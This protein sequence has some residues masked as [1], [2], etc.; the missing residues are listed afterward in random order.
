M[1]DENLKRGR[2]LQAIFQK[3]GLENIHLRYSTDYLDGLPG[4]P[5]NHYG[6][7]FIRG[8]EAK[9]KIS[10]EELY[11]E[12]DLVKNALKK[13]LQQN[14]ISQLEYDNTV[15]WLN[16]FKQFVFNE[17]K[18]WDVNYDVH[19]WL[20]PEVKSRPDPVAMITDRTIT[21]DAFGR[22]LEEADKLDSKQPV[23]WD[24]NQNNLASVADA[25]NNMAEMMGH[26]G[27]TF[28]VENDTRIKYSPC[29]PE[30]INAVQEILEYAVSLDS[31]IN[32]AVILDESQRNILV[33]QAMAYSNA[34]PEN[35]QYISFA[36][37]NAIGA[38]LLTEAIENAHM[39]MAAAKYLNFSS[40]TTYKGADGE[41]VYRFQNE[42]L[43]PHGTFVE[44]GDYNREAEIP[45]L[46]MSFGHGNRGVSFKEPELIALLDRMR[47]VVTIAGEDGTNPALNAAQKGGMAKE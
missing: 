22:L 2:E 36:E 37:A 25:L 41:D 39:A 1:P 29:E 20:P 12:L 9:E 11:R 16:S 7:F 13:Q 46:D 31:K 38:E 21:G 17:D 26:D 24:L 4:T 34:G 40:A 42:N 45:N 30:Q 19:P 32:P 8:T 23:Q 18:H 5:E 28:E 14:D 27:I 15:A 43:T 47:G 35:Y 6:F 33:T 10:V 3:L 44:G